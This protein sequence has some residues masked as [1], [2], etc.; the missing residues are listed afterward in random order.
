VIWLPLSGNDG[1]DTQGEKRYG[2]LDAGGT[3]RQSGQA[4][5]QLAQATAHA[6]S[7]RAVSTGKAQGIVFS[8]AESS[9]LVVWSNQ[10]A[11]SLKAASG[12]TAKSAGG[13]PLPYGAS[14]LQLG[15]DPVLV[16]VNGGL[17]DALKL[18]S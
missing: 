2:L 12:A 7:W 4:L 15:S 13:G 5:Q 3:V 18:L 6:S 16:T 1:A 14:G 11:A 9:T 17:Q 8:R 10:N